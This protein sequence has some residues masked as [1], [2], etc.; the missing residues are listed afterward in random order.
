MNT[1]H[2]A[3]STVAD[4]SLALL[5]MAVAMSVI[6]VG[7]ES[8]DSPHDEKTADRG[9]ELLATST[10]NTTYSLEP[11]LRTAR[12][13][14]EVREIQ[15]MADSE[16][17]E[18]DV[19]RHSHGTMAE[20]I[21]TIAILNGRI[22]GEPFINA[23]TDFERTLDERLRSMFGNAGMKANV[24]TVWRL[25]EGASVRGT[26]TFGN[27][28]PPNRNVSATTLQVPSGFK[29]I[30]TPRPSAG[31]GTPDFDAVGRRLAASVVHSLLPAQQSQRALE[32]K[33]PDRLLTLYRYVELARI[34]TDGSDILAQRDLQRTSADA[35]AANEALIHELADVLATEHLA[36]DFD[37]P[38]N[39]VRA[40][41]PETVTIT[42]RTWES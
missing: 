26:G 39:A 18:L 9:A 27:A 22:D 23:D 4:V 6:L 37:N 33:G 3:I 41:E 28:P 14:P 21:A 20:Q 7:P 13:D 11:V 34:A 10:G 15:P 19:N 36:E 31:N 17:D 42:I 32:S 38:S 29:P 2:R 16:R 8:T 25:Y 12:E 40:L 30:D 24:T 1:R 35:S 5:V